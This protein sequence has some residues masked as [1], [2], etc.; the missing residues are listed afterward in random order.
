[1]DEIATPPPMTKRIAELLPTVDV[2]VLN[3]LGAQWP[4][5]DPAL[6]GPDVVEHL[7]PVGVGDG[8][9]FLRSGRGP[10]ATFAIH[11]SR[12]HRFGNVPTGAHGSP[13]TPRTP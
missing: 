5:I 4:F 2:L 8:R 11:W 3:R 12:R 9:I 7:R 13:P 1:M 10:G 6:L